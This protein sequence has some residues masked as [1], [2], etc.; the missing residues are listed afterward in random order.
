[1]KKLSIIIAIIVIIGLMGFF[2]Q[3]GYCNIWASILFVLLGVLICNLFHYD[4][5]SL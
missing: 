1:M 3:K 2:D 4:I 5:D